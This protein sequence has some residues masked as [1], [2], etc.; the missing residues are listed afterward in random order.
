MGKSH[1]RTWRHSCC[2]VYDCV[3]G[4]RFRNLPFLLISRVFDQL[5]CNP[6]HVFLSICWSAIL[7]MDRMD[8]HRGVFEPAYDRLPSLDRASCSWHYSFRH[9]RKMIGP[10]QLTASSSD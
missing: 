2:S 3:L 10:P 7:D 8:D 4:G 9:C 6:A 1:A 5:H